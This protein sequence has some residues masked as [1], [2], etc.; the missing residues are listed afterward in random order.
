[1]FR[2]RVF[3]GDAGPGRI[4]ELRFSRRSIVNLTLYFQLL[5]IST[6]TSILNPGTRDRIDNNDAANPQQVKKVFYVMTTS[7]TIMF[8][9]VINLCTNAKEGVSEQRGKC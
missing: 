4:F 6:C 5:L 8:Y 9:V 3:F 2:L 1:M 7:T